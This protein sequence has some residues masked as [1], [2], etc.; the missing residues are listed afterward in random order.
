LNCRFKSILEVGIENQIDDQSN[1]V[2]FISFA[3]LFN[4][5]FFS[6]CFLFFF[7]F[8]DISF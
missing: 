1:L 5:L 4:L 2:A 8:I 3:L 6:F 7:Q